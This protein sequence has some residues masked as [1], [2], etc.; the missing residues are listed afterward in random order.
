MA[1]VASVSALVRAPIDT[2]KTTQAC[3]AHE[4]KYGS[5]S[6]EVVHG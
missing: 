3:N 5:I 4:Y 2:E 6:N 1:Q